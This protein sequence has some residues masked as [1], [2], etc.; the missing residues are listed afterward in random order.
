MAQYTALSATVAAMQTRM[1]KDE[2]AAEVDK[3]VAAGKIAPATKEHMLAWASQDLAA[4]KTFVEASPVIVAPG[5]TGVAGGPPAAG[6]GGLSDI[7]IAA[8][9]QMGISVEDYKK[10]REGK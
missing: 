6:N 9:S 4:F 8:C 7:E 10:T 2:A 3:A 5:G 1:V